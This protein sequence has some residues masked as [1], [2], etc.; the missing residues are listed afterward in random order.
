MMRARLL[1][2]LLVI[3]ATLFASAARADYSGHPRAA[4]LLKQL[5]ERHSF[6][7]AELNGVRAALAGAQRLPQLIAAEQT[8]AERTLNWTRYR[9]LHITDAQIDNGVRF[10]RENMQWLARAEAEYGVSPYVITAILGVETRYGVH[11]GRHRT[12]DALATQG[13]EHPRRSAFFFGQ[14]IEFFVLCRD[15]GFDPADVRGSYAGAIGYAQ[16]MPGNYRWLGVDFDGDGH[17][18]LWTVPDAIGSVANYLV[19]FRPEVAWRRDEPVMLALRRFQVRADRVSFNGRR[20]DSTLAKLAKLGAVP[21]RSAPGDLRAGLLELPRERGREYW[22]AL[23][24][25]YSIMSYN[26]S[27]FYA[28]AVAQLAE[29]IARA[30]AATPVAVGELSA[31]SPSVMPRR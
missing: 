8:S 30:A 6:T 31:T 23:T 20:P 28:M 19:R 15:Q 10:L 25:F 17:V 26:P 24:N 18:N 14:L 11:S 29:E 21:M 27:V 16:F 7:P 13:F 4:E 12:L 22:I 5:E 2:S 1:T 3:C 9:P